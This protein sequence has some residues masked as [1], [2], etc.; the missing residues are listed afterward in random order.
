MK[1]A[2]ITTDLSS[3]N[4]ILEV[5][6]HEIASVVHVDEIRKMNSHVLKNLGVVSFTLCTFA[7]RR[8]RCDGPSDKQTAS[9]IRVSITAPS[10]YL[11]AVFSEVVGTH[12]FTTCPYFL[13]SICLP[14]V[15]ERSY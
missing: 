12:D 4:C 1:K 8:R 6:L 5:K 11:V 10:W 9:V 14:A 7:P 2:I 15:L 3:V 13:S